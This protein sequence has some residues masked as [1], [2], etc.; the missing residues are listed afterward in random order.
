MLQKLKAKMFERFATWCINRA[1]R[2]PYEHLLN[3]DG[4]PHAH[5]YW[6][7]RIGSGKPNGDGEIYPF[8]AVKVCHLVSS[9]ERIFH[10]DACHSLTVVLRG[11]ICEFV[12]NQVDLW[13]DRIRTVNRYNGFDPTD[14]RTSAGRLYVA[15]SVFRRKAWCWHFFTLPNGADAWTLSV[16]G[17]KRQMWGYLADG[18]VKVP[19]SLFLERRRQR[20]NNN[21]RTR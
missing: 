4:T 21:G 20:R 10:D 11:A 2:N 16:T 14:Y 8:F 3:D 19:A 13:R 5:R 9:E 7:F 1:L 18:L 12:P 15:G 6:L 17:P